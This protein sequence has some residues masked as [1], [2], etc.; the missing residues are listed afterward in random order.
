M[1]K[2]D[3]CSLQY[4]PGGCVW[5]VGVMDLSRG[6]S[7]LLDGHLGGVSCKFAPLLPHLSGFCLCVSAPS[8]V[9]R[10]HGVVGPMPKQVVANRVYG[11]SRRNDIKMMPIGV[12]KVAYRVPGSQQADWYVADG[13]EMITNMFCFCSQKMIFPSRHAVWLLTPIIPGWIS[14]IACTVNVSFS[15]R[16][17]LMM[18]WQTK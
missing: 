17:K 1:D 7:F 12:P 10:S 2:F 18:S 14:T 3:C 16:V 4:L 9:P 6:T 13:L 5:Y 11:G 15:W 8:F